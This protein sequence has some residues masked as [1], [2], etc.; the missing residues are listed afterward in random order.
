EA[1]TAYRRAIELNPKGAPAHHQLGMLLRNRERTEEA[2][3]EIRKAVEL[4]PTGGLAHLTLTEMLLRQG[5]FA[6]ARRA[7]QR[8]LDLDPEDESRR[9]ALQ[10][11]H[12][13]CDLLPTLDVRLPAILQA[14]KQI[15]ANEQL[16]VARTCRDH[17]RP[18]AA[19]RLYAGTFAAQPTLA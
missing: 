18:Y 19:A 5:H 10:Q 2:L 11:N 14:G 8:G 16:G 3:A 7:A 13:E 15:G 1:M 6:E 12:H 17:G 9:P 4:D